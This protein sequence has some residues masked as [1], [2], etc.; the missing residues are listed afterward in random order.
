MPAFIAEALL[1]NFRDP[2]LQ[3]I[4]VHR[5]LTLTTTRRVR[6]DGTLHRAAVLLL[7]DARGAL[8]VSAAHARV[9]GRC[10]RPQQVRC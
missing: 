5:V 9:V 6:T 1:N 7:C 4:A 10:W 2:W 8:G 3:A